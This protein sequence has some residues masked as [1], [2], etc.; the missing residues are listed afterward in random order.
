MSEN[1]AGPPQEEPAIEAAPLAPRIP[2]PEG[3]SLAQMATAFA[4]SGYF[5]DGG[6]PVSGYQALTKILAGRELGIPPVASMMGVYLVSG[7]TGLSANLIAALVKRSGHYRYRVDALTSEEC[8]ITFLDG[9]QE[10][11]TSSFTIDDAKRAGRYNQPGPWQ[12][13]PRNMLWARAM[14]NGARWYCPDVFVAGVY[15]L[16][17]LAAAREEDAEAAAGD[18]DTD[19]EEEHHGNAGG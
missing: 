16:E 18:G 19:T 12:Q 15:T 4:R 9:E 17:E 13:Y 10:L 1:A 2:N 5:Q 11:G 6:R 8:I 14:S 7:R 3:L